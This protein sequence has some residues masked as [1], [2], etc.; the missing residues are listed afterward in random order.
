MELSSIEVVKSFVAINAG[1]S[2][3]PEVSVREEVKSGKLR[4]I[5]VVDSEGEKR[6]K[7]GVIYR[8]DRYL[9]I[10]SRRFLEISKQNVA[11][12]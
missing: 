6:N 7:M 8:K 2:I 9:S 10:A 1:I 11:L 3:A 12:E 4:A 5:K